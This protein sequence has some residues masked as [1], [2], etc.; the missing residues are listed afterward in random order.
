MFGL[1]QSCNTYGSVGIASGFAL[2]RFV[3]MNVYIHFVMLV[4]LGALKYSECIYYT[5]SMLLS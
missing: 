2:V 3:N 1:P 4:S 5:P